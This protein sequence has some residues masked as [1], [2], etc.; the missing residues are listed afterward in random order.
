MTKKAVILA[1]GR[2]D[3]LQRLTVERP[4]SMVPVAGR[5][6]IEY[7]LTSLARAGIEEVIIVLGYR[8]EQVQAHLGD[9]ARFGLEISYAWN[10][11]YTRGNA[12]SL[13]A[14]LPLTRGEP[15]LLVMADHLCSAS[16]FQAVLS[17]ADGRSAIAIDRSGLDPQR[18][19]EAT[20]VALAGDV[21]VDLGKGLER[22]QA[23]DTGVSYWTP[24]ALRA[25]VGAEPPTGELAA[26]MAEVARRN[27]ALAALDVS[28]HFWIDLDTEEELRLAERLLADDERRLD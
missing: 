12:S 25:L 4:K 9:G 22:W 28:G 14:A 20:K 18:I 13:W 1:A 7:V 19:E 23:I 3:R 16:L 10:A 26:F 24:D 5:P 17:K 21:I 27:G 15:F 11:E 2:G 6:V 8:G